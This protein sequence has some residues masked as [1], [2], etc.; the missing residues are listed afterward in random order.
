M[1]LK[2]LV[3]MADQLAH[4]K[5]IARD[6]PPTSRKVKYLDE[7]IVATNAGERV[8][9]KLEAS[10]IARRGHEKLALPGEPL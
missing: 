10:V 4:L 7:A 8:L 3:T 9:A 5:S 6:L 1:L 2:R